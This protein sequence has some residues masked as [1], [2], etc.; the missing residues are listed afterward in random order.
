MV[1]R[2]CALAMALLLGSYAV[3]TAEA[4]DGCGPAHPLWSGYDGCG[5]C[6]TCGPCRRCLP[7]IPQVLRGVGRVIN[8]LIPRPCCRCGHC[9]SCVTA[10]DA[11]VGCTSGCSSYGGGGDEIITDSIIHPSSSHHGTPVPATTGPSNPFGD[12]PAPGPMKSSMRRS[13]SNGGVSKTRSRSATKANYSPD[14]TEE[15]VITRP[16]VPAKK[17]KKNTT[18]VAGNS[19]SRLPSTMTAKPIVGTGVDEVITL[20][21]PSGEESETTS[22]LV[23]K[24]SSRK[25]KSVSVRKVSFAE[26]FD[27]EEAPISDRSSEPRR[28]S[29][30]LRSNHR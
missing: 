24:P 12:D 25:T 19:P 21:D 7:T 3:S 10:C 26:A 4:C 5:G 8:G 6:G 14:E 16:P 22:V 9:V 13:Y 29:N 27:E 15:R 20:D 1:F 18:K 28:S 2:S 11:P 17:T 23:K 30:P